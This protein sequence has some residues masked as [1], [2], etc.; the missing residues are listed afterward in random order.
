MQILAFQGSLREMQHIM[1]HL[2]L[3]LIYLENYYIFFIYSEYIPKDF[4]NKY[5]V[6]SEYGHY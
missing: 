2:Q 3:E 1:P 6:Y 4:I 5:G